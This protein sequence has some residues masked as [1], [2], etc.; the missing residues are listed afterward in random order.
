MESLDECAEKALLA[1]KK[2]AI[3]CLHGMEPLTCL[4]RPL[5]MDGFTVDREG[6]SKSNQFPP[7]C[8]VSIAG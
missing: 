7:H 8:D 1:E 4:V 6:Y 5:S 3:C 2:S